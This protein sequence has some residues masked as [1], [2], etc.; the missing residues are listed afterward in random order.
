[1]TRPKNNAPS[2]SVSCLFLIFALLLVNASNGLALHFEWVHLRKRSYKLFSHGDFI[3]AGILFMCGW[4][5]SIF[6]LLLCSSTPHNALRVICAFLSMLCY[7]FSFFPVAYLADYKAGYGVLCALFSL[8]FQVWIV[9][10]LLIHLSGL[11]AEKT[12]LAEEQ[13]RTSAFGTAEE[14]EEEDEE[15]EDE[16]EDWRL[17]K[18]SG[19]KTAH[20][21]LGH[22][23]ASIR[24]S[25]W[26]DKTTWT[27]QLWAPSYR[28]GAQQE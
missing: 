2:S 18:K 6:T 23:N 19:K 9:L 21:H 4:F 20:R 22:L 27:S 8:V 3:T 17:M 26:R 11:S 10:M 14:E 13:R 1:M 16:N 15:E 5:F 24:R 25:R 7:A 28:M 12:A